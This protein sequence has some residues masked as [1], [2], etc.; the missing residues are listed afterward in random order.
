MGRGSGDDA[1]A[2][3]TLEVKNTLIGMSMAQMPAG[4]T[5]GHIAAYAP[6]D[7]VFTAVPIWSLNDQTWTVGRDPDC[8]LSLSDNGASR[9]H[10]CIEKDALYRMHVY[11]D[12]GSTNGSIVNGL[13]VRR[14]FLHTGDMI[15][16]PGARLYYYLD[17]LDRRI[18]LENATTPI[19]DATRLHCIGASSGLFTV[20]RLRNFGELA[21]AFELLPL[22]A[23]SE[24]LT[25]TLAQLFP[26]SRIEAFRNGFECILI[27]SNA[28]HGSSPD[29][30]MRKKMR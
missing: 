29:F 7:A 12:K 30:A 4:M 17:I 5:S 10:G 25:S 21:G 20:V 27:T 18:E 26:F 6:P 22:R 28:E 1:P 2:K 19:T 14:A 9:L 13:Y 23:I 3:T 11:L 8:A 24:H 15:A 16:L